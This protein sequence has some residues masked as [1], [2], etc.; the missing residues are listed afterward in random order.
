MISTKE[1]KSAAWHHLQVDEVLEKLQTD[2]EKGLSSDEA[3]KRLQQFGPNELPEQ[4]NR[5]PL[6]RFLVQFHNM[7][8]YVLMAAAVVTAL[9]D[10]WIDTWVILAVVLINAIIGFVQEGKAEEALDNLKKML[11]LKAH[12]IRDGNRQE[13]DAN[14]VVP[15]DIIELESG[16]KIPADVRII[17]ERN[18]KA[19]ESALTGES[20]PVQKTIEPVD[21]D[22][23][24]GDRKS[25][26]YK[27]TMITYGRATAVV[28]GTGANTEIGKINTMMTEVE[29][30][31][32]PLIRQIDEFGKTLSLMII[33]LVAVMFAVGYFFHDYEL[34]DLFLAVIGL[35]VAAI[36][37]GLPAIMTI[38]LALGVQRMAS[39]NAI[40]RKLPSVETLGSVTVICSDKTGTLT[41]NEMTVRT[42]IT[43]DKSF[44]V[45]GT[46]YA[47]KGDILYQDKK[48]SVDETN[49]LKKLIQTVQL[50]N[51][52]EIEKEGDSWNLKGDPTE[53]A[54][55]T[56]GL[57]SELKTDDFKRLD[58]IPFE[59]E[60]K[61]MATLNDSGND[62]RFI[63]LKGA[64]ER[65]LEMCS[66]QQTDS[67]SE[68]LDHDY[69][70]DQIEA[71]A[72]KGERVM[73][74]A[75]KQV[76]NSVSEIDMEDVK[77][78]ITFLGLIGM[79][80][81]P[82]PEAI[83]A[84]KTCKEAG[85][86]VKMITGDHVST[87]KAIG[88]Q[89]GICDGKE[90]ITGTE[91]EKATDEELIE[92]SMKYDIF[93]RTSPEHKLRLVTAL[94]AQDEIVAMTGDGVNDAPALKRSNVG[95]AMGI[96]GTEVTK[97]AS[98][99]V[100]T[101]DNF[102]SIA[103]AV[104]EGRTIYDNL[105]K[106]IL[107]IL[108]TNG[109][110]AF[111]IL[112]AISIGIAL[113]ITPAQ[114][115]WVN[116]VTAVTLALALSFEPTEA[117]VMKRPPRDSK[118]P[119]IGSYFIWRIVFVSLLIG[120][121]TLLL[122]SYLKSE[123]YV[124]EEART[125][126]VNVLVAGQVFYLYNC[127]YL[128]DSI[129]RKGFFAN[130]YAQIAVAV[131]IVFQMVFVYAPFMNAWFGTMPIKTMYWGWVLAAGFIVFLLVELEKWGFNVYDRRKLSQNG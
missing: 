98:E 102:V 84:I 70:A 67:G 83:E 121:F 130:K 60:N 109:A 44:S 123:G 39:K 76:D 99:M 69:W 112:T 14:L 34:S 119:I 43:S 13:I 29:K 129:F 107:F 20:Q 3:E 38:T 26:G 66:E 101:D 36:P 128:R 19:E 126:A 104:K 40:I 24:I 2:Q 5:G 90:A 56:L 100:L 64:P 37:E 46:G 78:G 11:S 116:M 49:T 89:L 111:V 94:Q 18:L 7:L 125:I 63:F 85:I 51:N 93:A 124:I 71:I 106:T 30:L 73:A 27:S 122:Y 50:C 31:T 25:L 118:N 79:I 4:N 53:G 74:A 55:I 45:E 91:L 117:G 48:V 59:S 12:V 22:A 113:P 115:L 62:K 120:G 80:D 77:T 17:Y 1:Q 23:L 28:I 6:M 72:S 82:R 86:K 54:L 52:A 65:I 47:P 41:K 75:I 57:K 16:D 42:V 103:A 92:I 21:E 9:M 33:A 131:L 88:E 108:P 127:R 105:R 58:I 110:E 35:A 15:G 87:A 61:F 95:V 96:K 8:I 68:S 97:E 81:P 32:T 10:H 114:I